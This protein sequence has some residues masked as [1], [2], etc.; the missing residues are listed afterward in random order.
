MKRFL[1]CLSAV[2]V[3]A[4]CRS[5]SLPKTTASDIEK[6]PVVTVTMVESSPGVWKGTVDKK[7]VKVKAKESK[8]RWEFVGGPANATYDIVFFKSDPKPECTGSTCVS[9][10]IEYPRFPAKYDRDPDYKDRK[11]RRR[12]YYDINVLVA[13]RPVTIDPWVVIEK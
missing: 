6:D 9:E 7:T 4:S 5:S 12:I 2:V 1:F 10:T 3:L 11:D 8:I 13:G